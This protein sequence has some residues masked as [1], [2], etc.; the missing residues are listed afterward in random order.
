MT[1]D[2]IIELGK[3]IVQMAAELGAS[4]DDF[5]AATDIANTLHHRQVLRIMDQDLP[6]QAEQRK[7]H[8]EEVR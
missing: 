8:E 5:H 2:E 6:L 4:N 3:R 1:N 7:K